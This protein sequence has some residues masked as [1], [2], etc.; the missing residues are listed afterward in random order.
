MLPTHFGH[1]L[2]CNCLF[3]WLSGQDLFITPPFRPEIIMRLGRLIDEHRITF[4]SSVPAVWLA[5]KGWP[6]GRRAA[7][8]A[9]CTW[10]R[11]RCRP[12]TWDEIRDWTGT[13]QS[14]TPTASPRPQLVVGLAK[15]DV[16]AEDGLV[17]EGWG[18][19]V[20][21][22]RTQRHRRAARS[23]PGLSRRRVRLCVA[24]TRPR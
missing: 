21:V 17:G 9:A 16:P 22:L 13:R 10:A 18:A 24:G 7:A 12:N 4:M 8:C 14:A 11:H 15:A 2:I 23:R 1:G 3:P 5:L 20:R 6:N 19:V